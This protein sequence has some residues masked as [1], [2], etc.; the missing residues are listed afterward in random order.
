MSEYRAK[1]EEFR[2]LLEK[3]VFRASPAGKDS[4]GQKMVKI[5]ADLIEEIRA[6]LNL[7]V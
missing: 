5:R 2:A 1:T 7:S 6:A 3:M 4:T